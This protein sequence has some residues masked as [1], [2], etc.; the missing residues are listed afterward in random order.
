M[1]RSQ[2]DRATAASGFLG[3]DFL[4]A[5]FFSKIGASSGPRS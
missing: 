3:L 1:G 5:V 2:I 4:Q